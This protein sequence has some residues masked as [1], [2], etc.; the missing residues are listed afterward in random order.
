MTGAESF[1]RRA[2]GTTAF[3]V[4]HLRLPPNFEGPTHDETA[5][6]QEEVDVVLEGDGMMALDGESLELRPGRAIRVE[7]GV[8]RGVAA[9]PGG[10]TLIAIGARP[11]SYEPRG[12]F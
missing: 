7:P 5:S 1:L 2:L 4:N 12:P 6:G 3:G 9:G 10:V 8:W 11:G